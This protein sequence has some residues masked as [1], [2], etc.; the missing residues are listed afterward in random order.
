MIDEK[1]T[2]RFNSKEKKEIIPSE[3]LKNIEKDKQQ[4]V[5]YKLKISRGL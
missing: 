3:T 2:V 5:I 1:G 4:G